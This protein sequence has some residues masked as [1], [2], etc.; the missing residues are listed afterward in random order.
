ML[1]DHHHSDLF[2]M[3]NGVHF[4]LCLE[5]IIKSPPHNNRD[6]S[7]IKYMSV[8]QIYHTNGDKT[9]YIYIAKWK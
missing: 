9:S 1:F 8:G 7:H 5:E 2:I 3:T 6:F 4:M